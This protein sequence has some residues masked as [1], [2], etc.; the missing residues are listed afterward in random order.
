LFDR[1]LGV[2]LFDR[3]LA[4]SAETA[5]TNASPEYAGVA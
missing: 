2:A 1:R 5:S 4:M 3:M